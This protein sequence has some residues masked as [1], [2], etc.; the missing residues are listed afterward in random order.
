MRHLKVPLPGGWLYWSVS[1]AI[2]KYLKLGTYKEKRL[3]VLPVLEAEIPNSVALAVARAPWL[4]HIIA[5]GTMVEAY[6]R[7]RQEVG[8]RFRNQATTLSSG[9]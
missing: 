9:N 4:C 7:G 6:A 3:S 1:I 8:E 5:D 2:T